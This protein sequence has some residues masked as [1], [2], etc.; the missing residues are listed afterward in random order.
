MSSK[1]SKPNPRKVKLYPKMGLFIIFFLLIGA[2]ILFYFWRNIVTFRA[3][4]EE[5]LKLTSQ[6]SRR[7]TEY[8]HRHGE[9]FADLGQLAKFIRRESLMLMKLQE[10]A[11]YIGLRDLIFLS[12]LFTICFSFLLWRSFVSVE[13]QTQLANDYFYEAEKE[14]QTIK[15][16]T[17][18]VPSALYLVDKDH[19]VTLWNK[20]IA[21]ITGYTEE[22]ILGK[23]CSYFAEGPCDEANCAL[24]SP[25]V[26]KPILARECVIKNKHG[27]KLVV[28]KNA[29]LLKDVDGNVIGGIETF[30][31]I[32]ERKEE[33][34]E[35]RFINKLL[36]D[37]EE[38]VK[39][40]N[41]ELAEKIT[42]L[43]QT[44]EQMKGREV[45]IIEIKE[46][47]NRLS[48]ELGRTPPYKV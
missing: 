37:N 2:V 13:R 3:G 26:P 17:D 21:E 32:T 40:I 23:P 38:N 31:D 45:R 43:E 1:L 6:Y 42:A 48:Q 35:I 29:D 8:Y 25:E 24:F 22:E 15:Q 4:N 27:K 47:V 41:Q 36:R 39:K 10:E 34:E 12:L 11:L 20:K 30:V 18:L 44:N 16:F 9:E 33:E 28:S 5:I 19:R 7:V 14:K 46:E